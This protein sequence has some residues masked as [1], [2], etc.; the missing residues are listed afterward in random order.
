MS[1]IIIY[2]Q[3]IMLILLAGCNDSY[4]TEAYENE[5]LTI[6]RFLEN[7]ENYS[8]LYKALKRTQY[9]NILALQGEYT[10]WAPNNDAFLAY[11]KQ[12]GVSG[13]DELDDETVNKLVGTHIIEEKVT[14]LMFTTGRLP[15]P[16][17]GE[18][19]ILSFGEEGLSS[20]R[21]NGIKISVFDMI[22][23][24]G[25][26]HEVESVLTP[27]GKT[28]AE[29][30]AEDSEYSIFYNAM[31]ATGVLSI[32]SSKEE[33][34]KNR[35]TLFAES[36]SAFQQKG[37]Q[38]FEDLKS[39]YSTTNDITNS[40]DSLNQFMRYHI[41]VEDLTILEFKPFP[42]NTM[43]NIPLKIDIDGE[44][45][46]NRQVNGEG[47]EEYASIDL[48][49]IDRLAWNGIIHRLG[50]VLSIIE[51]KPEPIVHIG[52]HICIDA[53]NL[54]LDKVIY[55]GDAEPPWISNDQEVF[56]YLCKDVGDYLEFYTPYLF[57]VTYRVYY[58][59]SEFNPGRTIYG[60]YV[61][62]EQVGD[63]FVNI[64]EPFNLSAGQKGYYVGK[65]TLKEAG[66]QRLKVKV[67]GSYLYPDDNFIRLKKVYFEPDL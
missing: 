60:L 46:I 30:L 45:K 22:R 59:P 19:L 38:S 12:I 23:S 31:E 54:H 56:Q 8:E 5:D 24:N 57:D 2:I 64:H 66:R 50:S 11:Y 43:L 67:E 40:D 65:V 13:L 7:D 26:I 32:L 15:Y 62:D 25:V 55:T 14:S 10:L 16:N 47:N 34:N 42:Y 9:F 18:S 33:I 37:I 44:F 58:E 4:I 36:N 29:V 27:A 61:N 17:S 39:I 49:M 1:R 48:N 52:T 20:A 63:S 41:L 21:I 35:F 51:V 28:I 3:I 53:N 6:A